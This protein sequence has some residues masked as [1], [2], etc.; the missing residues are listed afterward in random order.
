MKL[1]FT[2]IRN[3]ALQ[4]FCDKLL[5]FIEM[6]FLIDKFLLFFN[7]GIHVVNEEDKH[8]LAI[9]LEQ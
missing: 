5:Y 8:H 2:M 4:A 7:K 1:A 6:P 9:R 3:I